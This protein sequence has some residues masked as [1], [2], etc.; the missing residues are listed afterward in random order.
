M[1]LK[2]VDET[3][4]AVIASSVAIDRSG[5]SWYGR[6]ALRPVGAFLLAYS[7][8][9]A[10]CGPIEYIS[11][12][13]NKAAP[14]VA[15]AKLAQADRY[16]P[17]EYTKAEEYLHKAREEAAYA[18]YQDAIYYGEQAEHFA[19][20]ARANSVARLSQGGASSP[21][22]SAPPPQSGKRPETE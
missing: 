16:S 21:A 1:V 6:R 13:A 10:G 17:Y 2:T 22:A 12:V 14:A 8:L 9:L 4:C 18:E 3:P 20:L 11:Q 19:N 15:A 5:T 7:A